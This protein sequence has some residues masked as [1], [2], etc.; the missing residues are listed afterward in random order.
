MAQWLFSQYPTGISFRLNANPKGQ[1]DNQKKNVK[2]VTLCSG[3]EVRIVAPIPTTLGETVVEVF[4]LDETTKNYISSIYKNDYTFTVFTNKGLLGV[5]PSID[6]PSNPG[7]WKIDNI[8]GWQK[9]TK[10]IYDKD[11]PDGY[12][13]WSASLTLKEILP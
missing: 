13:G 2:Y 4:H 8:S 11:N 3:R 1:T 7:Y 10:K 9:E 6:N 12:Q 5:L